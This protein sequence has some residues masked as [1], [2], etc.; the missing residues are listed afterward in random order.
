MANKITNGSPLRILLVEDNPAHAEMVMR[1][2]ETNRIAN[3]ITHVKDGEQALDYLHHRGVYGDAMAYP[4]PDLVLLDL[5]L[6]KIDGLEV[7][8]DIKTAEELM[9]IPVVILTTSSTD[10]DVARAY[11]RHAN[12]YLVKPIDFES[13]TRMMDDL[14][15]YWLA[16]NQNPF[17]GT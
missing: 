5:R 3:E 10:M 8:D 16:W 11:K 15:Y 2:F 1:S 6:P 9:S 17:H 12:S 14:G 4:R 7:L 13:F